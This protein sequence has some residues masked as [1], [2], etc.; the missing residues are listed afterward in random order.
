MTFP[1]RRRI[2]FYSSKTKL[3]LL[4]EIQKMDI[5]DNYRRAES[6][7]F[8]GDFVI[9][10]IGRFLFF[11]IVFCGNLYEVEGKTIVVITAKMRLFVEVLLLAAIGTAASG[12]LDFFIDYSIYSL[13]LIIGSLLLCGIFWGINYLQFKPGLNSFKTKLSR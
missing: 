12:L 11:N 2:E 8:T 1:L 9:Q 3:Q 6:E 13:E 10:T 4:E 5:D 7:T